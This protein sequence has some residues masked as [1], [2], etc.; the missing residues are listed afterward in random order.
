MAVTGPITLVAPLL[1]PLLT[2]QDWSPGSTRG[3]TPVAPA[4]LRPLLGHAMGRGYIAATVKKQEQTDPA[5]IPVARRVAL[6]VEPTMQHVAE[7]WSDPATGA[8]RFDGINPGARFTV[9]A[10]DHLHDWRAV[11]ADNLAPER[12]P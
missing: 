12:T 3:M 2:P 1:V 4:L 6:L 8:Y 10:F 5:A 7:T 9:V 11:I